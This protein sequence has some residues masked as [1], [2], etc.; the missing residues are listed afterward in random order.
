MQ[1]D[2]RDSEDSDHQGQSGENPPS[3]TRGEY[4]DDLLEEHLP[5]FH[6]IDGLIEYYFEYC[7]WIYRHVNCPAFTDAWSRYKAGYSGD[8]ITLATACVIMAVAVYYL[9]ERHALLETLSGSREEVGQRYY[10]VMRS[11]LQRHQA[12]SRAY[13]LELVE[14]LLISS[15]YLSLWKVEPEEIWTIRGELVSIG[16]AMGLHRDPGKW[17]MHRDVAER[18]RWAWWHI[19]LLERWALVSREKY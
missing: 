12:Q 8:R 11:V 2:S 16:T 7:N 18:R 10:D 13:S 3:A 14:L 1:N 5:E 6:V 9:P 15:H 4:D 19:V 17:K